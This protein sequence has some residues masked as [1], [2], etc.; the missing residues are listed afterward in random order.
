MPSIK[1]ESVLWYNVG[2]FGTVGYAVP[3]WGS[4]IGT[5]NATIRDLVET[6]GRNLF[7]F[8]HHDDADLRVPPS[9]NS[10]KRIHKLVMRVRSILGSRMVPAG[11]D[12]MEA[13]HASPA[14]EV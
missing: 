4:N 14:P 10:L 5:M 8:M 3:N 12:N 11:T 7:A 2:D 6:I 13:A 9:I 1:T